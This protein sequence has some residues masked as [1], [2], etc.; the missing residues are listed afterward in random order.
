MSA[1]DVPVQQPGARARI[2]VSPSRV[3]AVVAVF[4]IAFGAGY[5]AY[6]RYLAQSAPVAPAGQ[7][8]QVRRGSVAATVNATGS[9]VA[10]R[11]SKLT[12]QVSGRLKE[13]PVKLGDAVK[14]GGTLARVDTAPLEI[15]VEDARTQLQSAQLKLDQLKAGSRPEDVAAAEAGVQSAQAKLTDVQAGAT[16]QDIAQAQASVDAAAASVRS[17]QSKL[18]Q[19]KAGAAPADVSAAEQGVGNAKAGLDKAQIALDQLRAGAKPEDIR[20]QELAVEQA[21]NSLWAQQLSR[22]QTCSRTGGACDSA[23][24]SV[25]AAESAVSQ[26]NEKLKAL[27]LPPSAGDVAAKQAD[28]DS[29]RKKLAAEQVKLVQVRACASPEDVKQ[30]EAALDSARANQQGAVEK[31]QALKAGAKPAE[32]EAARAS[33]VQAQQQL[34]LKKSPST[35]MDLQLAEV[36]V[37]QAQ[38]AIKQAQLDFDNAT[39]TAPYDGLVGAITANIG[40]QIGSGTAILTLVD[41]TQ[42]RTDVSVDESDIA[43]IAPGMPAQISFDALPDR[44]FGGKVVGVSPTSTVTQ[45][46]ATYT[47]SVSIDNSDGSLPVGLTANVGIVTQQKTDVLLVPNRALRRAGRNQ[48]V[49]VLTPD[50][51][52]ETRQVTTGLGNDQVTEAVSGLAEGE[53]VL[54]PSTT[55]QQPRVG[56]PF[57]GPPPG[58]QVIRR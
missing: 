8:A 27:K 54:I 4:L 50:G 16:A 12:M 42:I 26:A 6:G 51:K 53:T 9:V 25:A 17:A 47:V 58:A 5:L 48:V 20:Q 7:P 19:V 31:L 13:L 30:A 33:L 52:T 18:D 35:V 44:R 36:A 22:D 37:K 40:E 41:P 49:D 23:R 57:G 15:K 14:A 10:S 46:V 39:L 28:V 24:A 21:K 32:I 2:G 1:V 11:Q 56:G 45:G 29:A 43:K 34:A 3:A 38:L 55:T